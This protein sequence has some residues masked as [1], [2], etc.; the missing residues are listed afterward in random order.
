V[1][2]AETPEGSFESRSS[3]PG[4]GGAIVSNGVNQSSYKKIDPQTGIGYSKINTGCCYWPRCVCASDGES[5]A[6]TVS[7]IAQTSHYAQNRAFIIQKYLFHPISNSAFI[8]IS[9]FFNHAILV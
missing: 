2:E 3:T 7:G 6:E 8:D 1:E 9:Q 4:C 5:V